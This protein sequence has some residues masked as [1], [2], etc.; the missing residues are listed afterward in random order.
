M[1]VEEVL[2]GDSFVDSDVHSV[3]S[4]NNDRLACTIPPKA[5]PR[6]LWSFSETT[7][8]LLLHLMAEMALLML[9]FFHLI[10]DV[11]SQNEKPKL[12]ISYDGQLDQIIFVCEIPMADLITTRYPTTRKQKT[13]RLRT[14]SLPRSKAAGVQ[15]PTFVFSTSLCLGHSQCDCT[16][17]LTLNTKNL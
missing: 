5:P 16:S 1:E 6:S 12:S 15:L 17:L 14:P 13:K 7:S 9:L 10:L 3:V 11:Y 2:H 4:R 8:V